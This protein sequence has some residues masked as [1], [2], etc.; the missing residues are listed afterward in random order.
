MP[1]ELANIGMP[2]ALFKGQLDTV[3]GLEENAPCTICGQ[4]SRY[5]FRLSQNDF[6]LDP[7]AQCGELGGL[8]IGWPD[9]KPEAT[10]CGRCA[11]LRD[12][13]THRNRE[14]I[15]VCY[16]CLRG[17]RAGI[18]HETEVGDL[19]L[20]HAVLGLANRGRPEVAQRHKLETTVLE[21]YSDGSQTIGVRLPKALL[22]EMLR[23]PRHIALQREYWPFH[24]NG[25]MT[26]LG[27]WQQDDFENQAPGRG[28]DWFGEHMA[29]EEPW[30]DMWEWLPEEVGLSY[31]Y[32]CQVCAQYRVFVDCD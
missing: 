10:R 19:D 20:A 25:F 1:D 29:P 30:E 3:S 6:L 11:A 26:Y 16:G 24:C 12:W 13:P 18:A 2:F 7:C 9:E 23:T 31:V 14:N 32:Q 28:R 21:T 4:L 8:R 27:R 15:A 17:G 5:A 22:M